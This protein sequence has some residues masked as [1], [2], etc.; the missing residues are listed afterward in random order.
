MVSETDK[1]KRVFRIFRQNSDS[2]IPVL[3]FLSTP[4]ELKMLS[5]AVVSP[6]ESE[7]HLTMDPSGLSLGYKQIS[8]NTRLPLSRM[9]SYLS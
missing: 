7:V 2:S 5:A 8:L 3:S 4:N 1:Y 9:A 6:N